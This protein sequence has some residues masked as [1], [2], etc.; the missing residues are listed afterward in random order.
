M[1]KTIKAF[2]TLEFK[3]QARIFSNFFEVFSRYP[4]QSCYPVEAFA[5]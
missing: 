3:K 5:K 4:Y 2:C 1:K